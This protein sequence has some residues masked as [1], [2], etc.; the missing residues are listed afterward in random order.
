[1][2]NQQL[3]WCIEM[4]SRKAQQAFGL[5]GLLSAI[6]ATTAVHAADSE[7]AAFCRAY[8]LPKLEIIEQCQSALTAEDI[9]N[10]ERGLFF[11]NLGRAL[12]K[13]DRDDEALEALV[14][15]VEYA[16]DHPR[17]WRET[18]WL[19][20]GRDE[21][22]KAVDAFQRALDLKKTASSLAGLGGSIWRGDGDVTQAETLLLAA[23]EL[24]PDWFWPKTELGWLYDDL[25]EWSKAL[26][27]FTKAIE[28]NQES[29]S[30]YFGSAIALNNLGDEESALAAINKALE[31]NSGSVNYLVYRAGLHR[32]LRR[33]NRALNDAK[34]AAR[35]D[36]MRAKAVIEA[37]YAL[38]N[39]DRSPEAFDLLAAA[40][41]RGV[42]GNYFHFNYAN[43]LADDMRWPDAL[44][45]IDKAIAAGDTSEM[46]FNLRSYILL[47]L[48]QYQGAIDAARQA[49]EVEPNFSTAMLNAAYAHADL[50]Q[51]NDVVAMM[52][53]AVG[54]GVSQQDIDTLLVYLNDNNN[55]LLAL[56]LR[57]VLFTQ[58]LVG[59]SNDTGA[60]EAE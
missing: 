3:I 19:L 9:S 38:G 34:T 23:S 10:A 27:Q 41:S 59:G 25:S 32:E 57:L 5:L 8:K 4:T 49:L 54:A 39:L 11:T 24:D 2:H 50:G 22:P 6:A 20:Y 52:T 46:D 51:S 30:S 7:A 28:F 17:A 43:T 40:D 21:F 58:S 35:L 55:A 42:N 15:A 60:T 56:R 12:R 29:S 47:N 36:P 45:Q 13:L 18:G 33:H 37:A 44:V 48:D 16:P 53:R 31:I 14:Q 1:M 26:E